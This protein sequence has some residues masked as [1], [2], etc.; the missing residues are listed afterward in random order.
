MLPTRRV[1]LALFIVGGLLVGCPETKEDLITQGNLALWKKD[2][3]GAIGRF[4]KVLK[5]DAGDVDAHRG[6]SNAHDLKGDEATA[7]EWLRKGWKLPGVKDQDRRFFQKRLVKLLMARAEATTD[8]NAKTK[9]LRGALEVNDAHRKANGLLA[10]HLQATAAQWATAGKLGEAADLLDGVLDL[11]VSKATKQKAM[12]LSVGH[13]LGLFRKD[14][15]AQFPAKHEQAL[16]AQGVYDSTSKRFKVAAQGDLP[17]T[18]SPS[19]PD[20]TR[21]AQDIAGG[22]AYKT[23]LNVLAGLSGRALPDPPPALQFRTWRADSEGW[24][25]RPSTYRYAASISYDEAA[26]GVFMIAQDERISAARKKA[27]GTPPANPAKPAKPAPR[28]PA[29]G[30]TPAA[31]PTPSAPAAPAAP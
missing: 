29:A 24:V 13:R 6:M 15:D 9:A 22:I 30:P 10:A 17:P 2:A 27:M 5:L 12:T 16:V 28:T 31:A 8:A 11:R 14:F 20:L 19:D 1:G 21:R 4:D 25:R 18:I 3:D 7:E 23:L 26:Q